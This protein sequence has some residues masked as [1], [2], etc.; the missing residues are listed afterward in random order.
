LRRVGRVADA[1][2]GWSPASLSSALPPAIASQPNRAT[3]PA[4]PELWCEPLI[5]AEADDDLVYDRPRSRR[6][7]FGGR[8]GIGVLRRFSPIDVLLAASVVVLLA[9]MVVVAIA[10]TNHV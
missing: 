7:E 3:V 8:W 5:P 1:G 9:A 6:E 4:E 10:L 2:G